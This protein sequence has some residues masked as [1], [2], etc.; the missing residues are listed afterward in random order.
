VVLSE[1]PHVQLVRPPVLV[2][3]NADGLVSSAHNRALAFSSH[4]SPYL[5][6]K[7]PQER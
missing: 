3:C 1:D 5:G 6:G 2:R 7:L 4:N